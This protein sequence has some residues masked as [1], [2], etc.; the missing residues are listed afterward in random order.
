MLNRSFHA[1]PFRDTIQDG[2]QLYVG[3]LSHLLND[4]IPS[5]P[6]EVA[7]NRLDVGPGNNLANPSDICAFH[8][9][10]LC[11]KLLRSVLLKRGIYAKVR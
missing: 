10:K 9:V 4:A 8:E 5:L 7:V 6:V 11:L 1:R 3:T 2:N